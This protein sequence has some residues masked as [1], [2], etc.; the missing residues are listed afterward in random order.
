MSSRQHHDPQPPD[1]YIRSGSAGVDD[2]GPDDGHTRPDRSLPQEGR[3][4]HPPPWQVAQGGELAD[5]EKAFNALNRG[6]HDVTERADGLLKA[7]SKALRTVVSQTAAI[8][9]IDALP[10]FCSSSNTAPAA[11]FVGR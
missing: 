7:T 2:G 5:S 9:R 4:R 6:V 3:R 8:T 10:S 11:Q 1:E